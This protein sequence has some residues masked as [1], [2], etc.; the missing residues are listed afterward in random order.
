MTRVWIDLF[1]VRRKTK[2]A[3]EVIHKSQ[4]PVSSN[5]AA[6]PMGLESSIQI[7]LS[8][9]HFSILFWPLGTVCQ[10]CSWLLLLAHSLAMCLPL[11]SGPGPCSKWFPRA[12][13]N[14]G[15]Q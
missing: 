11:N 14:S 15:A 8:R 5:V 7:P 6:V 12:L 2:E 4:I 10:L 3:E 1:H 13:F 9:E